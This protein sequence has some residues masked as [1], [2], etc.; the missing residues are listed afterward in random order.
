MNLVIINYDTLTNRYWQHIIL[1]DVHLECN[2]MLFGVF[3]LG[4]EEELALT[5]N[6]HSGKE[7]RC[8]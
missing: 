5:E 2:T 7:A 4:E 1:K 6:R 8:A 3:Y